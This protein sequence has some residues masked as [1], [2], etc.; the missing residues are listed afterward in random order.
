MFKTH[1]F[2][3]LKNCDKIDLLLLFLMAER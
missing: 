3:I 1:I 2:N